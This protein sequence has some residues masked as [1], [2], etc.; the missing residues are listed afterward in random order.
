[1]RV[2]IHDT[3]L[4]DGEQSAGVAFTRDERL[5]IAQAL[6]GLG[7]PELEVGIPA[8]G[9]EER[10]SI[11]SIAALGLPCALVAWGRLCETDLAASRHLAVTRLNLSMPVSDQMLTHKLG[12]SRA[13]ALAEIGRLIPQARDAGYAI[14]LGCEDA[15]RA[16]PAFMRQVAEIAQSAGADRLRWADTLGIM[17]P[18]GVYDAIG[19]LRR[20]VDIDLEIHAHDDLGLAT[21]NTLAAI[22]AGAT[23]ANTTV[24]GLGERAGNAPLEEV[25]VAIDLLYGYST[26]IELT[27]LPL[28]SENVARAAGRPVG[29]QKS[30]VGEGVFTHE[31]GIHV[32]GLL[33][34]PRNYQG[35]DPAR[36]GRSHRIVLGKHSGSRGVIAAYAE[37]GI[38]LDRA[39][40]EQL[41]TAIRLYV[42]ERKQTPDAATLLALLASASALCA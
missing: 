29:W 21:A 19:A 5:A 4:R 39:R 37:L 35:L 22:R 13:W 18:F 2:T 7:V 11:A 38:T 41:L 40:A 6:A 36:V 33:K 30:V 34:D 26:G 1:M 3:T 12:R 28:L 17:E 27:G 9:A 25:A 16:D 14:T 20:A 32:D 15:S 42:A 8:M 10:E 24:N 31:A 23:H